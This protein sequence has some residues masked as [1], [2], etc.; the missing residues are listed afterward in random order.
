MTAVHVGIL[1]ADTPTADEV[2]PGW[3]ALLIV[4]LMGVALFFLMRSMIKQFRKIDLPDDE[5]DDGSEARGAGDAGD[6][7]ETRE[8]DDEHETNGS[9]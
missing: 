4:F 3:T 9:R 1:L 5:S 8:H 7:D 2:K 6:V